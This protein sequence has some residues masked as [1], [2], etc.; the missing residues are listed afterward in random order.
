MFYFQP[1]HM[2]AARSTGKLK[3]PYKS[4]MGGVAGFTP[5]QFQAING[6]SN[7]FFGWGGEDDNLHTRTAKAFKDGY[8]RLSQKVGR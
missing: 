1:V 4:Y 8:Q 2:S 5:A 7:L 3:L 6:F